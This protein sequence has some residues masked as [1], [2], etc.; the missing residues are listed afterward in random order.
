MNSS[1]PTGSVIQSPLSSPPL[2]RPRIRDIQPHLMILHR[3]PLFGLA[4][5]L[6]LTSSSTAGRRTA[7]YNV[8][9]EWRTALAS[10]RSHFGQYFSAIQNNIQS[11]NA[12]C[13]KIHVSYKVHLR[14][15]CNHAERY[16]HASNQRCHD[17]GPGHAGQAVPLRHDNGPRHAGQAVPLRHDNGP[18]HAGQAV[19]A[20]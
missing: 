4:R 5:P 8:Y 17:N 18:R 9:T 12:N 11:V 6:A 19:P 15:Y 1:L 14:G 10:W 13:I 2:Y 20:K 7:G 3:R 16:H